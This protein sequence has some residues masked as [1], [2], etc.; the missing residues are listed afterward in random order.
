MKRLTLSVWLSVVTF[1]AC[2]P[3][4]SRDTGTLV[5][6]A[7]GEDFVRRGFVSEDGWTIGFHAVFANVYGP[8]AY[9]VVVYEVRE[10]DES[11]DARLV[12]DHYVAGAAGIL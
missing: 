12:I 4:V 7:N 11:D 2:G 10:A 5:F 9:Q 6:T 8:T 3:D 1:S